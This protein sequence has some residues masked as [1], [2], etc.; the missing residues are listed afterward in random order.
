MLIKRLNIQVISI[1]LIVAFYFN[2]LV[3]FII[4]QKK[5]IY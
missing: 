2:I 4:S 1:E 5:G 3:Y